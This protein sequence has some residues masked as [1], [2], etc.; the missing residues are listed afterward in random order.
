[1]HA[2]LNDGVLDAEHFRD[3]RLQRSQPFTSETAAAIARMQHPPCRVRRA[4]LD[5]I[6][7][8]CVWMPR[9]AALRRP[10][11]RAGGPS[12]VLLELA[13]FTDH[14]DH[15]HVHCASRCR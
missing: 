4:A 12:H 11:P 10:G 6:E 14:D 8:W 2:G 3:L 5:A 15:P 13:S 1:M 9:R 7:A